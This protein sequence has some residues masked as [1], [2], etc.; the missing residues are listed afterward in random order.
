MA[1]RTHLK[2]YSSKPY[3]YKY[4][5]EERCL[6]M[7]NVVA[8]QFVKPEKLEEFLKLGKELVEKTTE[9]DAGCMAYAMYQDMSNPN[10]VT[11]M[12]AWES[13]EALDK[14]GKAAHFVDLIPKLGALCEKPT[15]ISLYKKLF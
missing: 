6:K 15:E 8:K 1:L 2:E 11:V 7:L 4:I 12:E 10:I 13:Q 9:L 5:R 14:H 3:T